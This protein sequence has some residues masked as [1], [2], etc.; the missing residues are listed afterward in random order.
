MTA[1]E[2]FVILFLSM[3]YASLRHVSSLILASSMIGGFSVLPALADS[4][5][6]IPVNP[7]SSSCVTA[8]TK[9]LH[10]NVTALLARDIAP[11]ANS[12]TAQTAIKT[13]RMITDEAWTAMTLPYCG[14][15]A[16]GNASAVKSYNKTTSRARS[17]FLEAIAKTKKGATIATVVSATTTSSTLKVVAPPA[18][19]TVA[20][21]TPAHAAISRTRIVP[22]MSIGVRSDAVMALQKLLVAH[23]GLP[24]DDAHVTGYFGNTTMGLIIKFQIEKKIVDS[25][26]DDGAGTVGPRTAAALN[27][28]P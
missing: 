6:P 19:P 20:A 14:Y 15:G 25:A 9:Q 24:A 3:R 7:P 17:S 10:A 16:Y 28:L 2:I 8:K 12:A 26:D 5:V 21:V 23:F 11:Y 13:Y 18:N 4:T 1:N 22:G 27:L